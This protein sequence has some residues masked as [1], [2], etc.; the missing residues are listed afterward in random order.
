MIPNLATVSPPSTATISPMSE[1]NAGGGGGGGIMKK[2]PSTPKR[3]A[4]MN[5]DWIQY[6]TNTTTIKSMMSRP[7]TLRF[8]IRPQVEKHAQNTIIKQ[9][10][11]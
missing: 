6:N 5:E 3:V 10:Y 8:C 7:K 1:T 2:R 4:M 9:I 11:F